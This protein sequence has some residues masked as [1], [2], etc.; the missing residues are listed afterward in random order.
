MTNHHKTNLVIFCGAGFSHFSGLPLM[1]D[2]SDRLR[3][4]RYLK[5]RQ[6][7]ISNVSDPGS[8]YN[9]NFP[10]A[11]KI[12]KLH[13]S[14]NWFI[15]EHDRPLIYDRFP[16]SGAPSKD[17]WTLELAHGAREGA[18]CAL[19]PPAALKPDL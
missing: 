3:A 7:A 11:I 14:T 18:R 4:S 6:S 16:I 5:D 15:D 12:F 19:V 13:G 1:A 10:D 2:F 8:I 17:D 9:P